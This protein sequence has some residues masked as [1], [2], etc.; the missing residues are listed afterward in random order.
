MHVYVCDCALHMRT[1]HIRR[2]VAATAGAASVE[3][4]IKMS[5]TFIA[6]TAHMISS[7]A[8]G[9]QKQQQTQFTLFHLL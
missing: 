8:L 5:N 3:S 2:A 6:R 7:C 1:V 4:V 9:E